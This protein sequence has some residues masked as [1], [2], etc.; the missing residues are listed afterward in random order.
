MSEVKYSNACRACDKKFIGKRGQQYC[1]QEC[2]DAKI[3]INSSHAGEKYNELTIEK[4]YRYHSR[5]YAECL[6]SCGKKTDVRYDCLINKNTISCGHIA[7]EKQKKPYDLTNQKNKYGLVALREIDHEKHIWE[8]RCGYC[9][10]ITEVESQY[11]K[12]RKSCGCLVDENRIENGK[13]AKSR[14][15]KKD[16]C[17]YKVLN[18]ARLISSNTSGRTGVTYK[19]DRDRWAA[20]I[21]FQKKH[22]YLG[23]YVKKEDAIHAREIAEKVL[24]NDFE[25]W[26][27]NTYPEFYN[28]IKK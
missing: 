14:Y 8:C 20:Q 9:G 22:Y 18:P 11:F 13:K 1:S 2:K 19:K 12:R 16:T 17:A 26:Y 23:S 21:E 4:M 6:C 28:K 7:K 5:L 10:K 3:Y 25:E 15:F 24:L 27:K